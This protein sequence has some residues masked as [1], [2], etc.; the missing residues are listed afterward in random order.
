MTKLNLYEDANGKEYVAITTVAE[1]EREFIEDC[2]LTLRHSI[3]ITED[4]TS[5]PTN[6]LLGQE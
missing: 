6:R 1:Y 3:V 5:W 2:G 4:M